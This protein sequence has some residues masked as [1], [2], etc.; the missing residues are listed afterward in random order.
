MNGLQLLYVTPVS[1]RFIS[2]TTFS[3]VNQNFL[4]MCSL[5]YS[6]NRISYKNGILLK[7]VASPKLLNSSLAS[8]SLKNLDILLLHTPHYDKHIICLSLVYM[9][10]HYFF[11]TS[12]NT[13]TQFR[14]SILYSIFILYSY[15][16][17]LSFTLCLSFCLNILSISILLL[18]SINRLLTMPYH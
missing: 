14:Y 9:S 18:C 3:H 6:Y 1:F 2:N 11:C 7:G 10:S 4:I 12:N 13:M 5:S 17:I 8:C 16:L 15:I